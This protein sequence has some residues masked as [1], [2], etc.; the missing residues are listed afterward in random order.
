MRQTSII[1]QTKRR[2][3]LIYA[4]ELDVGD[5][6][7]RTM[8]DYRKGISCE[9]IKY[10]FETNG[11]GDISGKLECVIGGYDTKKDKQITKHVYIKNPK[12]QVVY[13]GT[14]K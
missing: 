14:N 4:H 12:Q 6:F 7:C 3:D 13:L 2:L 5:K 11:F 10:M 9:V 8:G 1:Q